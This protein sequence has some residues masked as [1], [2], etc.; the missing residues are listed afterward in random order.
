[1]KRE[2]MTDECPESKN[3]IN[4]PS[5]IGRYFLELLATG[6]DFLLSFPAID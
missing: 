5:V 6:F 3:A 2:L 4:F 1:M